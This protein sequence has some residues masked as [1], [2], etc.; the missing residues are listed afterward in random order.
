MADDRPGP[1]VRELGECRRTYFPP[2]PGRREERDR[3]PGVR[4]FTGP[5]RPEVVPE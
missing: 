1:V 5:T 2:A 3:P 4:R